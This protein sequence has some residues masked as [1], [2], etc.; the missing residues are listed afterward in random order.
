MSD[1]GLGFRR[2]HRRCP[3]P[4]RSRRYVSVAGRP[5]LLCFPL[6]LRRYRR[7]HCHRCHG[8][9]RSSTQGVGFFLQVGPPLLSS[10][11]L[12]TSIGVPFS[13]LR[14]SGCS[15]LCRAC[16][17][18]VACFRSGHLSL[19]KT[20]FFLPVLFL[21]VL[22]LLPYLLLFLSK[23]GWAAHFSTHAV[24]GCGSGH[25]RGLRRYRRCR[26]LGTSP[27]A[28]VVLLRVALL[29]VVLLAVVLLT[30]VLLS[31][32]PLSCSSRRPLRFFLL[33]L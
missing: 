2:P 11:S 26:T 14:C 24:F 29:A 4:L 25:R 10:C 30:V 18:T 15:C 33:P 8:I 22:P 28:V 19:A 7:G 3:P 9:A 20:F 23:Y 31:V 21:L 16:S 13:G 12:L 32:V 5:Y 17:G 1:I 6:D 27:V